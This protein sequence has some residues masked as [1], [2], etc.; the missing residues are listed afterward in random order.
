MVH[1]GVEGNRHLDIG[2]ARR[3]GAHQFGDIAAD[4]AQPA[5]GLQALTVDPKPHGHALRSALSKA[6]HAAAASGSGVTV[7]AGGFR[8]ASRDFRNCR[9]RN[10]N[11]L[12]RPTPSS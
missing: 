5:G 3:D 10:F 7:S 9:I 8:F 6:R 12:V 11:A 4:A 1:R 2:L